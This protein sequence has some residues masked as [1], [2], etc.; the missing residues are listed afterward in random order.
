LQ[1]QW[2]EVVRQ[3]YWPFLLSPL[4]YAA[5][6]GQR[7]AMRRGPDFTV[8]S[9]IDL[10]PRWLNRTLYFV[11]RA[12]NRLLSRKPFGSSLFVVGRRRPGPV[13]PPGR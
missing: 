2:F 4:I 6:A 11:T 8:R 9:D 12:E 13:S 7:R 10:P 5:R 3:C 1:P